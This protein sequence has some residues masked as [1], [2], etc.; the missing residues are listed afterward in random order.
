MQYV[1]ITTTVTSVPSYKA[2]RRL[3]FLSLLF[4]FT[5]T[6]LAQTYPTFTCNQTSNLIAEGFSPALTV[7]NG[8]VYQ[9]FVNSATGNLAV[10]TS[11]DGKTFSNPTPT[12][13]HLGTGSPSITTFNNKLYI[14]YQSGELPYLISS[15]NGTTWSSS[16]LVDMPGYPTMSN[17]RPAIYA[18][19]SYLYFAH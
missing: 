3:A 8:L 9:A 14:A 6:I 18:Y 1:P 5:S 10:A 2:L 13:V 17:D 19:G 16:E 11:A 12:G 4:L 7:F 15:S